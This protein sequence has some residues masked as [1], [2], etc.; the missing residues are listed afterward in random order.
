LTLRPG[1]ARVDLSVLPEVQTERPEGVTSFIA[2]SKQER[3]HHEI[4][5]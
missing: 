1:S 5:R 3:P 2:A 4:S